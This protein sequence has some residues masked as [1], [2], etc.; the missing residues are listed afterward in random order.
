MQC[1]NTIAACLDLIPMPKRRRKYHMSPARRAALRKAQLASAK[2][3]RRRAI[4]GRVG[5]GVVAFSGAMAAAQLARWTNP[6]EVAR[7]YRDIKK[8]VKN[9][10]TR[11]Q[12]KKAVKTASVIK[13]V[14]YKNMT[15]IP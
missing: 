2:K 6:R 5:A 10:K 9:L 3:R 7:D 13:P 14:K 15:W 8:G 4:A 12:N 1:G 11:R